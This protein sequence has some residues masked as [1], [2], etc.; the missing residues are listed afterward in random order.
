M[1][2][3][4]FQSK[5]TKCNGFP[6]K[7]PSLPPLSLQS[8]IR[9]IVSD[10]INNNSV[11]QSSRN[12]NCVERPKGRNIAEELH[13]RFQILHKLG[14]FTF[15]NIIPGQICCLHLVK[16][17]SITPVTSLVTPFHIQFNPRQNYGR[18]ST[19]IKKKLPGE[20][21]LRTKNRDKQQCFHKK[22]FPSWRK[23]PAK[24]QSISTKAWPGNW[25]LWN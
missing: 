4:R 22:I 7:Q 12:V 6:S 5:W 16:S 18:S 21:K 13:E 9:N 24:I 11:E 3:A 20:P 25:R 1:P 2:L 19:L 14:W 10:V 17:R 15:Q 23:F 8:F